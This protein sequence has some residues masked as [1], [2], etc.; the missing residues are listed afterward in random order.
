MSSGNDREGTSHWLEQRIT[1]IALTLLSAIL[2]MQVFYFEDFSFEEIQLWFRSPFHVALIVLFIGTGFHHM[3]L[4][5][6]VIVEDY[7]SNRVLKNF[8]LVSNILLVW[9]LAITTFI[10]IAKLYL[11]N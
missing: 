8:L 6:K 7:I 5:I 10:S 4:G 2:V 1:A 9:G 3:Q 11:G